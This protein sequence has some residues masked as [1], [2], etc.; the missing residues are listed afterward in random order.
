[1]I[2]DIVIGAVI[3]AV[4]VGFWPTR[5]AKGP[6][7]PPGSIAKDARLDEMA[8]SLGRSEAY[9]DER[10]N[11]DTRGRQ[12]VFVSAHI[13]GSGRSPAHAVGARK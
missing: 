10:D 8:S 2:E 5:H 12:P 4:P 3:V 7:G 1:M 11:L 9:E 13:A 6:H